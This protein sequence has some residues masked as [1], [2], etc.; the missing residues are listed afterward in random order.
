[1]TLRSVAL[2]AVALALGA[3]ATLPSPA[4]A[5]NSAAAIDTAADWPARRAALL[6]RTDFALRGR[7]AVAAAGEGFSASLRWSQHGPVGQMQLNGP[8]GVGA[9][10]VD[11]DHDELRVTDARGD[12]LSGAA[13]RAEL[14]RRLGFTLPLAELAYW[15]RG[16]GAPAAPGSVVPGSVAVETLDAAAARLA[17]LDQAGWRVDYSAYA[18]SLLGVLPRKLALR[19]DEVRIRLAIEAWEA[20]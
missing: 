18:P 8:L 11:F 19:R 7:V 17:A 2:L 13:A 9:L 10:R 6:A 14:E 15:V 16:V 1:M 12:E 4:P 3:C 20:P 5:P